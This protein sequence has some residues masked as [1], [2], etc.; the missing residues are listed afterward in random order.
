MKLSM[1]LVRLRHFGTLR[2]RCTRKQQDSCLEG[3]HYCL[4]CPESSSAAVQSLLRVRAFLCRTPFRLSN[5][6]YNPH[7]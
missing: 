4:P 3:L 1:I 5:P 7:S 6:C 2:E